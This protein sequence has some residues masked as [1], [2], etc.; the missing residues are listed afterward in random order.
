MIVADTN[1]V[2]YL[3]IQGQYTR[4]AE[5]VYRKDPQWSA[6]LLWRSEFRDVLVFYLR[7]S[8]IHMEEALDAMEEAERLMGGQEFELESSRV[9]R[10]AVTWKCSAYDCEFIAL[11]QDLGVPLVTSDSALL[12]KFKSTA[13]SMRSFCS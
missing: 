2:A 4:E 11:A 10:M 9:L 7:R 1:L 13:V 8:L 12:A 3:L 6:P 5:A